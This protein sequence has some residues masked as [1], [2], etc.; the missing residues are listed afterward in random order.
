MKT[1][2]KIKQKKY[3]NKKRKKKVGP[4]RDQGRHLEDEMQLKAEN[5]TAQNV[6]LYEP[7]KTLRFEITL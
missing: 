3:E 7:E 4:M 6:C 1:K 2:N 5:K